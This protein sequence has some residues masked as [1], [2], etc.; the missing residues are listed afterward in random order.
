MHAPTDPC[1]GCELCSSTREA[2][3]WPAGLPL[4]R[5]PA[6]LPAPLLRQIYEQLHGAL[7]IFPLAGSCRSE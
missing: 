3:H 5:N 2:L 1:V 7:V 6:S 4:T